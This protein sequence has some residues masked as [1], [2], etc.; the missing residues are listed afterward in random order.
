MKIPFWCTVI[1]SHIYTHTQKM[2]QTATRAH[3]MWTSWEVSS[4]ESDPW[5]LLFHHCILSALLMR[6]SVQHLPLGRSLTIPTVRPRRWRVVKKQ[7]VSN[8]QRVEKVLKLLME[9]KLRP[10]ALRTKHSTE[11]VQQTWHSI[12]KS[13]FNTSH[14]VLGYVVM[15]E[16]LKWFS[17]NKETCRTMTTRRRYTN[18]TTL[19][20]KVFLK[21]LLKCKF[22]QKAPCGISS[23]VVQLKCGLSGPDVVPGQ[24]GPVKGAVYFCCCLRL[25]SRIF[26]WVGSRTPASS[27][28]SS[29]MSLRR[30][31]ESDNVG[32]RW[33]L[34]NNSQGLCRSQQVKLNTF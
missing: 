6:S 17:L 24:F 25:S 10:P 30:Q 22:S 23:S 21:T 18:E 15:H 31:K 28:S 19:D 20:Q 11:D 12:F 32:N 3:I 34:W 27:R 29:V 4:L 33:C 1:Y 5:A 9:P 7:I 26:L 2:T 14:R 8:R 16:G 13:V